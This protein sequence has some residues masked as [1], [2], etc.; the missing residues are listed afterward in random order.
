MCKSFASSYECVFKKKKL[1]CDNSENCTSISKVFCDFFSWFFNLQ[2]QNIYILQ[3]VFK[4]V[5]CLL[6]TKI[7]EM[8]VL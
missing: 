7:Y 1:K 6:N 3:K 4:V 8:K 5:V 2:L